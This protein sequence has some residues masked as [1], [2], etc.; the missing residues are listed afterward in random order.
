MVQLPQL[1]QCLR[2]CFQTAKGGLV[3][4][5]KVQLQRSHFSMCWKRQHAAISV[6]AGSLGPTLRT[7][8]HP[9]CNETAEAFRLRRNGSCSL[10]E[11]PD[12]STGNVVPERSSST[13]RSFVHRLRSSSSVA[14]P[15]PQSLP[16]NLSCRCSLLSHS[17]RKNTS[18]KLSAF[19]AAARS[20]GKSLP[21]FISSGQRGFARNRSS[22]L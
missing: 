11:A 19:T 7:P 15:V 14:K 13:S 22:R 20:S 3:A 8:S 17:L 12:P 21:S 2:H 6:Q 18:S 9:A 1:G 16:L 5:P 10:A 4:Q